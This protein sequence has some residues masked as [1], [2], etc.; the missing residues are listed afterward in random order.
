[1]LLKIG[2][3]QVP[4]TLKYPQLQEHVPKVLEF[5]PFR[6]WVSRLENDLLKSQLTPQKIELQDVDFFGSRIGF[7]KVKADILNE[8]GKL[9]PGI[10]FLRGDA[11]G[12]LV[13]IT[14]IDEHYAVLVEQPRVPLGQR[15]LELPAGMLDGSKNFVGVAAQELEEECGIKI[16]PSDLK[17]LTKE[18]LVP[19]GGGC[20]ERI[21]LFL[22]DK[23]MDKQELLNLQ[24][25]IGG[26]QDHGERITI[27]IVKWQ[28]IPSVTADM[29]AFCALKLL[30]NFP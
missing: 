14:S 2:R 21:R 12:V 25:R 16:E 29:K 26:L 8:D 6:N 22:V 20:D 3:F 28:D 9:M 4:I 13:R 23:H 19:S 15:F 24:D 18:A 5:V 1:M 7:V 17:E 11:V 27:K 10:A 30:E